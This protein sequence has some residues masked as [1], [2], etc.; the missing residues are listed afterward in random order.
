MLA[1]AGRDAAG[2]H[3]RPA[4][5]RSSCAPGRSCST[6]GGSWPTAR[7]PTCS[8]TPSCW[9]PTACTC[10]AGSTPP[11]PDPRRLAFSRWPAELVEHD[12]VDAAVVPALLEVLPAHPVV[13]VARHVARGVAGRRQPRAA[14]RPAR[15]RRTSSSASGVVPKYSS[16]RSS[17]R[18]SSPMGSGESSLRRSTATSDRPPYP[19][20]ADTTST[21]AA[22]LPR[23]SPPASWPGPA[24]A[25]TSRRASAVA[26]SPA[27]PRRLHGRRPPPGRRACCPGWRKPRAG[28]VGHAAGPRLQR[29]PVKVA[30]PP[31]ASTT[32]AWRSA[33]LGSPAKNSSSTSAAAPVPAA[34]SS[35]PRVR[36]ARLA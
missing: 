5:R 14:P 15:R 25:S 8:P 27:E 19:P 34:S 18:R 31:R 33:W 9:P 28:P 35:R 1:G 23:G 13:E 16:W 30:A 24:S 26:G 4:L 22:C 21:A 2:R 17:I 10:P 32:P 3:P 6:A 36:S 29:S 20:P 11:A 12:G 7:R